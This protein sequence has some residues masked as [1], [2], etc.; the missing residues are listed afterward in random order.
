MNI[1]VKTDSSQYVPEKISETRYRCKISELNEGINNVVIQ[2]MEEGCPPTS[3][4]F[5]VTYTKPSAKTGSKSAVK[6]GVAIRKKTTK[7]V[8][9][10]NPAK[11]K[12]AVKM[13]KKGKYYVRVRACAGSQKS[14]WSKVKKAK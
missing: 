12:K 1:I 2:I 14:P 5:E 10:K 13:K 3:S 11:L 9:I 6:E 7:T 4:S 8:K